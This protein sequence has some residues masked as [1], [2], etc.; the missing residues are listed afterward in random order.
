[1]PDVSGAASV[2][3]VVEP[4]RFPCLSLFGL[5]PPT[6]SRPGLTGLSCS[7]SRGSACC[8]P[9]FSGLRSEPGGVGVLNL[10]WRF[11]DEAALLGPSHA[12]TVSPGA[13]ALPQELYPSSSGCCLTCGLDKGAVSVTKLIF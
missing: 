6:F 7:V 4:R 3:A 9:R 8:E 12:W 1:M 2:C 5:A 11:F 13:Q 10:L